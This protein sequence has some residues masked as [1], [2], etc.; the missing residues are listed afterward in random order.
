MA[1]RSRASKKWTT[2]IPLQLKIWLPF[3]WKSDSKKRRYQRLYHSISIQYDIKSSSISKAGTS[4]CSNG[5][6][7]KKH[8]YRSLRSEPRYRY[9]IPGPISKIYRYRKMVL[10]YLYTISKLCASISNFVFSDIGVSLSDPAW[11]AVAPSS[12]LLGT[13]H[14]L[15]C[16]YCIANQ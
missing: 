16:E 4:I 1:T 2:W 9:Y 13:G 3:N 10:R 15:R 5:M 12:L 14:R 11:A 8:R 6:I 7:S